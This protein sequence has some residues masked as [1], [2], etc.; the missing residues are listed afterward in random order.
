M[1]LPEL[2][3]NVDR[4]I[5]THGVRYYSELTNMALLMEECGE[6]ARWMARVYGDQSFKKSE[7]GSHPSQQIADELA[8]ILFVITCIANQTGIDLDQAMQNNLI[9]KAQRDHARHHSNP[10]LKS[11]E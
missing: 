3:T 9:K 4:W 6:L 11:N 5:Q 1:T 2:Q 10:K 7:E 8:D